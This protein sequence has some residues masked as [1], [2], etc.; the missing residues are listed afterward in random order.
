MLPWISYRNLL[1]NSYSWMGPRAFGLGYKMLRTSSSVCFWNHHIHPSINL[2]F[3]QGSFAWRK[4]YSRRV[5][6]SFLFLPTIIHLDS[7]D[8]TTHWSSS[9]DLYSYSN[10][11]SKS[12]SISPI[13]FRNQTS[14]CLPFLYS[15]SLAAFSL[16]LW[17]LPLNSVL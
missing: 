1:L 17:E 10:F 2:S 7:S 6:P 8:T 9:S 13:N 16:F 4:K 5:I 14:I 15:W 3:S 11:E 12:N